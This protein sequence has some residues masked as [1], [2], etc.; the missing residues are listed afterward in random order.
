MMK[1][2]YN[3]FQKNE[4]RHIDVAILF[5]LGQKERAQQVARELRPEQVEWSKEDIEE[6]IDEHGNFEAASEELS[7]N[8]IRSGKGTGFFSKYFL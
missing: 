1:V 4:V 8:G 3:P 6:Y 5:G 7:E 2:E